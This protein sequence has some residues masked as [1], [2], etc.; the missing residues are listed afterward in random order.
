MKMTDIQVNDPVMTALVESVASLANGAGKSGGIFFD[1]GCGIIKVAEEIQRQLDVV[2]VGI[3][4]QGTLYEP[5]GTGIECHICDFSSSTGVAAQLRSFTNGRKIAY[6]GF[7][8]VPEKR[9]AAEDI[10]AALHEIS[11]TDAAVLLAGAKNISCTDFITRL[12]FPQDGGVHAPGNACDET[13]LNEIMTKCGWTEISRSDIPAG[14]CQ[15]SGSILAE[16]YIRALK[17]ATDKN[18]NTSFFIRMYRPDKICVEQPKTEANPFL[19]IV[20]RTQGKRM[21]GLREDFL[22]LSAQTCRDFEVLV[23]GH[24]LSDEASAAV[25]AMIDENPEWLRERTRLIKV[26]GGTRTT[27][28][29]TGFNNA[30]GRYTAIYDDDDVVFANWV[31]AFKK[32]EEK[33]PSKLLHA[34]CVRQNWSPAGTKYCQ[35]GFYAIGPFNKMYIKRYD[36]LEQLSMNNCPLMTLAFPTWVFTKLGV[37]FDESLTTTED[38]DY[39]VRVALL[40]G[41]ADSDEITSLYRWWVNGESSRTIVSDNE[42]KKNYQI[43]KSKLDTVPILLP[44]GSAGKIGKLVETKHKF[45]YLMKKLDEDTSEE[46]YEFE[47]SSLYFDEGNGFSEDERVFGDNKK[48]DGNMEFVFDNLS[49]H[50]NICKVRWDPSDDIALCF[51]EIYIEI[52]LQSGKIIRYSLK[53]A[54]TNGILKKGILWLPSRDPMVVV[55]VDG[56]IEN[57]RIW[58]KWACYSENVLFS[59]IYKRNPFFYLFT[60]LGRVRLYSKIISLIKRS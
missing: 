26:F 57:V 3:E 6:I 52:K 44:A 28:L 7:F 34:N 53:Q 27:P 38:W 40:C 50:G 47:E 41:V 23:I 39:I 60:K 49:D 42:W 32:V 56:T 5:V 36:P 8:C 35:D 15:N 12:F 37:A 4:I 21:A 33:N 51:K 54:L 10:L 29:I 19:S 14:K 13:F 17:K 31:E 58:G 22:C 46:K 2:Y 16:E 55:P 9:S 30:K 1:I 18:A 11:E 59:K 24:E 43:I 20:I 45:R 48:T 25:A